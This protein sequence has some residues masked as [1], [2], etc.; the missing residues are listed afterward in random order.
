M[1]FPFSWISEN[2]ITSL[3]TVT[4]LILFFRRYTRSLLWSTFAVILWIPFLHVSDPPVQ[5]LALA[6][7]C[8]AIM[9]R[10]SG[11]N[12]F[13]MLSSY[14]VFLCAY[15]IRGTYL[16][17]IVSFALFDITTIL[18]RNNIKEILRMMRPQKCDWPIAVTLF[19]LT[20]FSCLQSPHPWNNVFFA[21]DTWSPTKGKSFKNGAFIH[22]YNWQYIGR[23]YGTFDNHDYFITNKEL[24]NGADNMIDAIKANPKFVLLQLIRNTQRTFILTAKS[25][26]FKN[27]FFTVVPSTGLYWY[28]HLS[29]SF[30]LVCLILHGAFH[31]CKN[32][33]MFIFLLV[34]VFLLAIATISLPKA[35]YLHPLIPIFVL[36]AFWYGNK[37]HNKI[38]SLINSSGSP[39]KL[40]SLTKYLGHS[41]IACLFFEWFIWLE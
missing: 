41:R 33:N 23:K 3:F 25:T 39:K 37:V 26:I 27:I 19:A 40:L 2:I 34:N 4:T 30:S 12:R 6:F 22:N 35:R 17:F 10:D 11:P 24:F 21:S 32:A 28:L 18:R 8:I 29:V 14:A 38:D 31:V 1:G 20:L 15:M 7:S 16:V 9:L 36:S 13:R 5:K